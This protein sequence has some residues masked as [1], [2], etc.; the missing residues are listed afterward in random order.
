[1]ATTC[2]YLSANH[3]YN[4]AVDHIYTASHQ[5]HK[6]VDRQAV[7]HSAQIFAVNIGSTRH[8]PVILSEQ[9]T[10]LLLHD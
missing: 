6:H 5:T 9:L 10:L 3:S 4:H 8:S 1:L 7:G 2:T